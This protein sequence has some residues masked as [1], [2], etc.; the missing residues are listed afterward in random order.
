MRATCACRVPVT[1]VGADPNAD[2]RQMLVDAKTSR[3]WAWGDNA[4]KLAGV[5]ARNFIYPTEV[6]IHAIAIE[7]GDDMSGAALSTEH[8]NLRHLPARCSSAYTTVL[9][10]S[11]VDMCLQLC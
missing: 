7:G 5:S 4:L 11:A 2:F 8:R 3:L 1:G 9:E 6:Y 10:N